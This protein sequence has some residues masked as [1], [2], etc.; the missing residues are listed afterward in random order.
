M[1]IR[2]FERKKRLLETEM[3]RRQFD[4]RQSEIRKVE[5][6]KIV[7]SKNRTSENRAPEVVI[8][9]NPKIRGIRNPTMR[10]SEHSNPDMYKIVIFELGQLE[11]R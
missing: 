9:W 1:N 4:L 3:Q 6:I 8:F 5:L 11:Q 10:S 2:V 7:T